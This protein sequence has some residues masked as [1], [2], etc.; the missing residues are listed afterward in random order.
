VRILER[1]IEHEHVLVV[2]IFSGWAF[3][4]HLFL[5]ARQTLEDGPQ[6]RIL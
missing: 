2:H 5:S 3:L 4:E 1:V 6:Q